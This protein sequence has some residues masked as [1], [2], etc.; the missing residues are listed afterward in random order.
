MIGGL[1]TKRLIVV[2]G[3]M[4]LVAVSVAAAALDALWLAFAAIG[5]LQVAIFVAFLVMERTIVRTNDEWT[6][7]HERR[8][9]Q[10][11]SA[12]QTMAD[13]VL[14]AVEMARLDAADR[15][16]DIAAALDGGE[17]SDPAGR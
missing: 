5:A 9:E 13:R 2:G 17:I 15:H 1:D 8:M 12:V 6:R 14:G 7:S 10:T 11:A 3:A 16:A 4:G